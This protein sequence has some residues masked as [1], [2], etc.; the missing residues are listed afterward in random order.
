MQIENIAFNQ[1]G[2]NITRTTGGPGTGLQ[3]LHLT[4]PTGQRVQLV[5]LSSM[6][7][8]WLSPWGGGQG[9]WDTGSPRLQDIAITPPASGFSAWTRFS[10]RVEQTG[11]STYYGQNQQTW[12]GVSWRAR[13]SR[14]AIEI[15]TESHWPTG[16]SSD[17]YGNAW[18]IRPDVWTSMTGMTTISIGQ[19]VHGGSS[20]GASGRITSSVVEV[21]PDIPENVTASVQF[22][23]SITGAVLGTTTVTGLP[24]TNQTF[25]VPASAPQPIPPVGQTFSHWNPSSVVRNIGNGGT[26]A[27]QDVTPVFVSHAI[28]STFHLNGGH[29]G[30]NTTTY[31]IL[32]IS[33]SH[34]P[35]P[36]NPLRF[37]YVFRGWFTTEDGNELFDFSATRTANQTIH[38][39]WEPLTGNVVMLR[40]AGGLRTDETVWAFNADRPHTMWLPSFDI[41]NLYPP[42]PGQVFLGWYTN[43]EFTGTRQIRVAS[44]ATGPQEFFGRWT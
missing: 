14:T 28:T 8:V 40:F 38:A 23:N 6:L 31:Q 34:V 13:A 41:M 33:G 22:R 3:T 36:R 7:G 5:R 21:V 9:N 42:S 10:T 11:W 27:H 29:I 1:A 2:G 30:D 44:G 20:R 37:G 15:Q 19:N 32:F 35:Q 12:N 25:T 16:H 26:L 17:G 39:Q 24:N 18:A 43:P 4:P